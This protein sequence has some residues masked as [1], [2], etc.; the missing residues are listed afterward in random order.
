MTDKYTLLQE[1]STIVFRIF[2]KPADATVNWK[3]LCENTTALSFRLFGVTEIRIFEL[4]NGL[5]PITG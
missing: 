3:E 1:L 2:R 4:T 5:L